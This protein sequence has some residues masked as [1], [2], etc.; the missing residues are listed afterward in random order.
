MA[1]DRKFIEDPI[2]QYEIMK[3]LEKELDRVGLAG[4][5]IQRTPVVTRITLVVM[6]P[7]RIIGRGGGV[8]NR[9]TSTLQKEFLIQNP[10]ISVVAV[11]NPSLEPRLVGKRAARMVEMGKKVRSVLHFLLRDIMANGAIGAELVISGAMSKGSRAKSMRAAAGF[12]P[13]AG[14]YVRLVKVAHVVS[15]TKFGVI[16]ILVRIV[17]PGTVFPEK[18]EAMMALPK[19]IAAASQFERRPPGRGRKRRN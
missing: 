12:I 1:Y 5:D 18:A 13:K 16:G 11:Q 17:P 8:I 10:Q 9:L 2:L 14:D 6:N 15:V 3:Y 4:I 19:V 7:G